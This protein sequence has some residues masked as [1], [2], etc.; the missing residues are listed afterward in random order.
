[1]VSPGCAL[2]PPGWQGWRGRREKA[3]TEGGED[4]RL[5]TSSATRRD[6]DPEGRRPGRHGDPEVTATR[7][8]R[9]PGSHGAPEVTATRKSSRR[10]GSHGAPEGTDVPARPSLYPPSLPNLMP[11]HPPMR[12]A[13]RGVRSF[14]IR[15]T[16]SSVRSPGSGQRT[17]PPLG[18]K[19]RRRRFLSTDDISAVFTGTYEKL[20]N[21]RIAH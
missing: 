21:G 10:P 5:T 7:K 6:G 15:Q 11:D 14:S 8:S 9:R 4:P 12:N 19:S 18:R 3:R 17:T 13:F 16:S 20:A 2:R 1:M